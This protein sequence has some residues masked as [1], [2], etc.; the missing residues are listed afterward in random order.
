MGRAGAPDLT[1][2][3]HSGLSLP[4]SCALWSTQRGHTRTHIYL[5]THAGDE[6]ILG[7][8]EYVCFLSV[9]LDVTDYPCVLKRVQALPKNPTVCVCF[10]SSL[11]AFVFT[12]L[13]L[14]AHLSVCV[15]VRIF[16]RL[17]ECAGAHFHL[18]FLLSR[19]SGQDIGV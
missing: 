18:F 7:L 17:L 4:A 9:R 14:Y 11:C 13:N 19:S 16:T 10:P 6:D 15:C 1:T 5:S 8:C 3:T 2:L 12:S